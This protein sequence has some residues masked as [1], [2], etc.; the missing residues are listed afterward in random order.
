[1]SDP[2][3]PPRK[4]LDLLGSLDDLGGAPPGSGPSA[5]P[6]E[7]RP[8]ERSEVCPAPGRGSAATRRTS[9]Y[10]SA[11]MLRRLKELALARDCK[12][13]DLLVEGAE[14]VLRESGHLPSPVHRDTS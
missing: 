13:N 4:R 2:T 11:A 9:V 6:V 5:I 8:A 1:M 3:R 12:V 14:A 7:R 10:L